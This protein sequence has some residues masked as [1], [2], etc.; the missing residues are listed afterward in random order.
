M[1]YRIVK[2]GNNKFLIQEKFGWFDK[3][4]KVCV[5]IQ[6]YPGLENK[7]REYIHYEDY[8]RNIFPTIELARKKLQRII[9]SKLEKRRQEDLTVMHEVEI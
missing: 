1:K 8:Q 9:E 2:N 3:W 5:D 6:D 4:E 7:W